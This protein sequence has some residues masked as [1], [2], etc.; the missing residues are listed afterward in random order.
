MTSVVREVAVASVIVVIVVVVTDLVLGSTIRLHAEEI[1]DDGKGSQCGTSTSRCA[2][3]VCTNEVVVSVVV[4]DV[5]IKKH[6]NIGGRIFLRG[7]NNRIR[8]GSCSMEVSNCTS[9]VLEYIPVTVPSVVVIEMTCVTVDGTVVIARS[10]VL[11]V[12]VVVVVSGNHVSDVVVVVV[13]VTVSH[14]VDVFGAIWRKVEQNCSA[15]CSSKTLTIWWWCPRRMDGLGLSSHGNLLMLVGEAS[16]SGAKQAKM[17]T[18]R[19]ALV[20]DMVG[21]N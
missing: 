18:Q 12:V 7:G 10:T 6:A 3:A 11:V 15:L 19:M 8:F 17:P 4:L 14:V 5:N 2:G 13:G 9:S 21:R 16:K 20:I 1:A